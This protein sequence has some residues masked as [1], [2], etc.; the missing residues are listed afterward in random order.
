MNIICTMLEPEVGAMNISMIAAAS[1]G[2][3]SI[4]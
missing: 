4:R 3:D 1:S 2:M